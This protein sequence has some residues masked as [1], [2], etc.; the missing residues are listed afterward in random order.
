MKKD[1]KPLPITPVLQYAETDLNLNRI[2]QAT[3]FWLMTRIAKQAL[4]K[5]GVT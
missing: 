5:F 2:Q 3:F 1:I 4:P